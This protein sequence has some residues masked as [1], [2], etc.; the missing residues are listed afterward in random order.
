[1]S[2]QVSTSSADEMVDIL[3]LLEEGYGAYLQNATVSP[4]STPRSDASTPTRDTQA[5]Q[6]LQDLA[7][8]MKT[9]FNSVMSYFKD[10]RTSAQKNDGAWLSY[11]GTLSETQY[12]SR[13]Y[14][15]AESRLFAVSI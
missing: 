7:R 1:M 12:P 5:M 10:D 4:G 11:V 6:R 9:K 3:S 13:R 15:E 2:N 8:G 14:I